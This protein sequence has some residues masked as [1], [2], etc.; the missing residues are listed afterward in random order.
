VGGWGGHKKFLIALEMEHRNV[1]QAKFSFTA[2]KKE[3]ERSLN[4]VIWSTN[5]ML[6]SECVSIYEY[7]QLMKS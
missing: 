7:Q 3:N 4:S 5:I 2:V 6:T 1:M